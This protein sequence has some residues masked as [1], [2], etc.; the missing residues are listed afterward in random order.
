MA[1]GIDGAREFEDPSK[2]DPTKTF[3]YKN[4][5]VD[6]GE[7]L[8]Y[9]QSTVGTDVSITDF[10]NYWNDLTTQGVEGGLINNG[11]N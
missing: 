5:C 6:M 3:Q 10:Q 2:Y 11:V 1:S 8:A 9:L 4:K 7:F